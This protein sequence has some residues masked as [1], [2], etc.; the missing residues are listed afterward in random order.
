M[1]NSGRVLAVASL[2]SFVAF[3]D[4]SV[5]NVAFPNMAASFPTTSLSTLSWV[6]SGYAVL[7][8]AALAPA[9]RYADILGRRAVFGWSLLG[10]TVFSALCAAAPDIG[11]LMV[12]R[13]L[14]GLAAGG[15]I[16]AALG[17]VLGSTPPERR[18]GAVA[19]WT[20]AGSA[21]AA[22]GPALGGLLV[23][24][25]N[26]RAVFVINVPIGLVALVLC[27]RWVPELTMPASRRPDS[28]GA[29]LVG[30]GV[31]GVAVG[32]TQGSDWGW[33]SAGFLASAVGGLAVLGAGIVRSRA[34]A[35]PALEIALWANRKFAAA[36]GVSFFFGAAMYASLLAAPVFAMLVWHY[37]VWAAGLAATP[38]AFTAALGAAVVGRAKHPDIARMAAVAGCL[39]FAVSG[40]LL[41]TLLTTTPRFLAIW[42]PV[43]LLNGF[44]VGLVLTAVSG[45]AATSL[46]P[47]KFASG[48]GMTVTA[49]QVGGGFG[50]AAFAAL[51]MSNPSSTLSEGEEQENHSRVEV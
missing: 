26:W 13:A 34:H 12:A 4:M 39:L 9:G 20:A 7:F 19:A 29:A 50:I 43:G 10:F 47:D 28:L 22:A 3:L 16:P 45:A 2:T 44:A 49:R 24:A 36:G 1:G 15:M 37:R 23:W 40:V 6:I 35:E 5:V 32:L 46:P 41:A 27:R 14:Q 11:V 31:A 8:A 17:L 30:L 18:V 38:G 21:A 25:D 51:A 42:L 33:T 48:Y